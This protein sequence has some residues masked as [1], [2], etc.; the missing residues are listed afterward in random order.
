MENDVVILVDETDNEVG[1]LEKL[2][3]HRLGV[4]HR[5]FSVFLFDRAGRCL[6]HQRAESKYH[7]GGLWTN[8]C[9]SHPRP[10]E[11]T[12]AG[13]RRRLAEEL[14]IRCALQSAFSFVYR[15]EFDDG[16]I[17]HEYDHVYVGLFDGEPDPDPDEV[18]DWAWMTP[19]AIDEALR[20][21][22]EH[23]T[24]WFRACYEKVM[25]FRDGNMITLPAEHKP[26]YR[27]EAV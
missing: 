19:Q 16:L 10:G 20:T 23:F 3:A 21:R 24:Y 11:I 14:G 13:A 26:H 5:A 25:H 15:A 12:I 2:A 17:E 1:V 4:L 6:L 8:A 22:P 27:L 9:C 18:A 7:S